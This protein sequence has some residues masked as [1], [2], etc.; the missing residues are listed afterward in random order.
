MHMKINII[1]FHSYIFIY[2]Y[3][4]QVG[5]SYGINYFCSQFK[6]QCLFR[7]FMVNVR[8]ILLF[9]PNVTSTASFTLNNVLIIYIYI[10]PRNIWPQPNFFPFV[11]YLFF[12]VWL[13]KFRLLLILF[14]CLLKHIYFAWNIFQVMAGS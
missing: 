13:P 12:F 3:I 7:H 10:F 1:I 5:I 6:I 14:Y 9:V 2:T 4:R 8:D 11:F